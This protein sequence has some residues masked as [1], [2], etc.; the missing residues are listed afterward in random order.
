MLLYEIPRNVD[1]FL[2]VLPHNM[3]TVEAVLRV[4]YFTVP[5]TKSARVLVCIYGLG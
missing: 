4:I 3:G 5:S 2:S 1:A